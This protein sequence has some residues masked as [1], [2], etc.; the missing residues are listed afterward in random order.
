MKLQYCCNF[1]IAQLNPTLRGKCQFIY[2]YGPQMAIEK[3]N[4]KPSRFTN[5]SATFCKSPPSFVVWLGDASVLEK[6]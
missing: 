5:P 2:T 6:R 1:W 4:L 3:A